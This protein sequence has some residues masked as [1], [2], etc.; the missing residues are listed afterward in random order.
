[1]FSLVHFL[2][3]SLISLGLI[4]ILQAKLKQ[5]VRIFQDGAVLINF[6]G[7]CDSLVSGLIQRI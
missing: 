2:T 1:M 4:L 7:N 5:I 3:S 6:V